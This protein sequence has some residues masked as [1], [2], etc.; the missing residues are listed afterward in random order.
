H[1]A[2]AVRDADGDGAG[3]DVRHHPGAAPN[4]AQR[5]ARPRRSQ[6]PGVRSPD[7]KESGARSQEPESRSQEPEA[8]S[9]EPE[10]RS[11]EPECSADREPSFWLL[12]S[13]SFPQNQFFLS[14][15]LRSCSLRAKSPMLSSNT[16][17]CRAA[18]SGENPATW[19]VRITFSLRHSGWS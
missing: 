14:T 10:S 15:T 13:G 2:D 3:H 8:R 12:N 18:I 5:R 6:E 1:L 16:A 4:P 11:Q 17:R 9:Q 7:L 19:G